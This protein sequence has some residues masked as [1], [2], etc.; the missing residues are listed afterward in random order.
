MKLKQLLVINAIITLAYGLG[1]TLIP[2]TILTLYGL[3]SDPS[4]KLAAQY[5]GVALIGVGMLSWC[6]RD[7]TD[8]KAQQGNIVSF[9]IYHTVG[10]I[11]SL[12]GTLRGIFSAVGWTAVAIY[13]FLGIGFAYF[14]FFKRD[15]V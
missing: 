1:E 12:S 14:Q 4:T 5:F 2:G 11:V 7:V 8:S 3:S 9:L 10:L 15:E 13:L 6:A